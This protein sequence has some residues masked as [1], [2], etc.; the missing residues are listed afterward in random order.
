MEPDNKSLSSRQLEELTG[1]GF[2]SIISSIARW[3]HWHNHYV[4]RK[5]K[6][7][8]YRYNL[9]ASGMEFLEMDANVLF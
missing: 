7:R 5:G 3:S 6:R 1:L 8:L 9:A 2:F 4:N